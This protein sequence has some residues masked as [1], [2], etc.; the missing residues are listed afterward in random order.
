MTAENNRKYIAE[1]WIDN[2]KEEDFKTSFLENLLDQLQHHKNIGDG[3]GFDADMV[4]GKHYCEIIQEFDDKINDFMNSFSIGKVFFSKDKSEYEI[5]FEGVKLFI[6]ES[7]GYTESD[8]TLPWIDNP[9]D[10]QDASPNLLEVFNS[11]YSNLS[12]KLDDKVNISDF[13]EVQSFTEA[14]TGIQNKYQDGKFNAD[15]VNGLRFHVLHQSDYDNL[16]VEEKESAYDVYIIKDNN[17]DIPEDLLA[18]QTNTAPISAYY[19]FRKNTR[20]TDDEPPRIIKIIEYHHQYEGNVWHYMCDLDALYDEESIAIFLGDQDSNYELNSDSVIGALNA[21]G[22]DPEHLI[23]LASKDYVKGIYINGAYYTNENNTK[24][25]VPIT[26]DENNYRQLNL[27]PLEDLLSEKINAL[28]GSG[29]NNQT[30]ASLASNLSTLSTKINTA[31]STI[32][33][34]KGS[35]YSNET[36]AGLN[37][38]I[39]TLNNTI[40]TLGK[41]THTTHH[42]GQSDLFYNDTLRLAFFQVQITVKHKGK[43]AH[44]WNDTG[45]TLPKKPLAAF[46]VPYGPSTTVR[47]DNDGKIY[48]YTISE[49][50]DNSFALIAG[51]MYPY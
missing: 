15:S 30:L 36:L 10:P 48:Y 26:V 28:K 14:L 11:L 49:K 20:E 6:P 4:D 51:G 23:K 25:Q 47:F 31:Q 3:E 46:R 8:R 34:L 32:N 41:W 37:K 33:S 1:A 40:N 19:E 50:D 12:S 18:G 24:T 45:K 44:K 21:E 22:V 2:G 9:Y 27:N 7:D 42:G 35:G 17:Y 29:Y 43:N 5:T 16:S 13:E 38:S 39:K